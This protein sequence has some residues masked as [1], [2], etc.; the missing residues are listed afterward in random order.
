VK[1]TVIAIARNVS[2][3]SFRH[4]SRRAEPPPAVGMAQPRWLL[5]EPGMGYRFQPDPDGEI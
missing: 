3:R 4:C 1:T 5:T 2:F